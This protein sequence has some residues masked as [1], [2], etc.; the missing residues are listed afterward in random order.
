M[1]DVLKTRA[2]FIIF[3]L[4]KIKDCQKVESLR[5]KVKGMKKTIKTMAKETGGK[6]LQILLDEYV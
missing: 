6:G 1:E 2:V 4:L 5:A 3:P